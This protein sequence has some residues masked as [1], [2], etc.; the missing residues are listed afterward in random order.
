MDRMQKQSILIV[1]GSLEQQLASLK[2]LIMLGSTSEEP[3]KVHATKS[4]SSA[5][6][7]DEEDD[8][9]EKSMAGAITETEIFLHK[10][11]TDKGM[12]DGQ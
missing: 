7:S 1:L 12:V 3:S 8:A 4:P 9:I 2:A 5:Y 10:V 6:T 11:A